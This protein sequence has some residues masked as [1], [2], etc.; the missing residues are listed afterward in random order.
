MHKKTFNKN[1]K[2][3]ETQ[4]ALSLTLT[5]W[6]SL[7]KSTRPRTCKLRAVFKNSGK[8][9]WLIR[10]S[11]LYMKLNKASISCFLTSR[12]I[13]MG[14]WHGFAWN[15]KESKL[16]YLFYLQTLFI[17]SNFKFYSLHT[18]SR[19]LKYGLHA[20]S[21]T[22]CA[23]NDWPSQARVTSIKSSWSSKCLNDVIILVWNSFQRTEY[24][25]SVSIPPI[26]DFCSSAKY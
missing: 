20:E 11:P 5:G 24:N 8:C 7:V 16:N 15:Y 25:W 3:K 14:C 1:K 26:I 18:L 23:V 12:S 21:T 19:D 4:T 9:S 2:K 22:L 10:T 17:C 13:T 6:F